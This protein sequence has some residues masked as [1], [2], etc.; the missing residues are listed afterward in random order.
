MT[1]RINK[2]IGAF[3]A[4]EAESHFVQ[5]RGEMLR[6]NF[7]PA[8]DDS[9]L[10]KREC[11]LD[12]VSR[13]T[14]AI[15][16][17]RIFLGTVIHGFMFEVTNRCFVSLPFVGH[18]HFHILADILADVFGKSS[19]T[20]IC[21]MKESQITTTLP[22][23]DDGFLSFHRSLDATSTLAT[24]DIGFVHFDSTVK[25][26]LIYFFHSRTNA[27]T[28]IPRG[29]VGAFV[30]SPDRPLELHRA[31]AFL[32]FADQQHGNEPDRQRKMRIVEDRTASGG[33]LVFATN[34][35]VTGIFL[36]P[37]YALV[38]AAGADQSLRPS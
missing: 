12:C 3:P 1:Q 27:M 31:H 28:E 32:G 29:F 9:P 23:A 34:T 20:G 22:D 25:H 15:F 5:I 37:R 8:S 2:Q 6:A 18:N 16:I 19:C 4:I 10:E 24:A 11:G 21:S 26:R 7:V 35:L 13:D 36:K 17:S 38:F 30:F 14:R 33:E